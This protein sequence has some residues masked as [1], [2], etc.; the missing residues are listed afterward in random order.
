MV[1]VVGSEEWKRRYDGISSSMG[2]DP[3]VIGFGLSST[4]E[5]FCLAELEL[6][7]E[8]TVDLRRRD[9]K[10]HDVIEDLRCCIA[11][12][13][14][15][16]LFLTNFLFPTLKERHAEMKNLLD[17]IEQKARELAEE[18]GFP[19]EH[20]DRDESKTR[21]KPV[22]DKLNL[23]LRGIGSILEEEEKLPQYLDFILKISKA[24]STNYENR[25]VYAPASAVMAN[26]SLRNS[27]YRESLDQNRG[28]LLWFG[29]RLTFRIKHQTTLENSIKL[30]QFRRVMEE[31]PEFAHLF[32]EKELTI[33]SIYGLD[34][35]KVSARE[36]YEKFLPSLTPL[37]TMND[38]DSTVSTYFNQRIRDVFASQ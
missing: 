28:D 19:T 30:S 18:I 22:K 36:V 33:S 38:V 15:T 34:N 4:L 9:P 8:A 37:S 6:F 16:S 32:G 27:L 35:R 7:D 1:M 20:L 2:F 3:S 14:Y 10:A 17:S 5:A 13:V 29:P 24:T 31:A 25:L 12:P 21:I 26:L 23:M 11:D